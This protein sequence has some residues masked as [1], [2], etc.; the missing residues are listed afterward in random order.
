MGDKILGARGSFK[1]LGVDSICDTFYPCIFL[2]TA[3]QFFWD[4]VPMLTFRY[5]PAIASSINTE[6]G[7]RLFL[8]VLL[9]FLRSSSCNL[10]VALEL[11][12]GPPA[13]GNPKKTFNE[14]LET[15]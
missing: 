12:Y 9:I 4:S 13:G 6:C 3:F 7:T 5:N 10:F 14:T 1:K 2:F 8:E 15:R 11:Y